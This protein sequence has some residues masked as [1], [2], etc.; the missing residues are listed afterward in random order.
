[1][2]LMKEESDK[3]EFVCPFPCSCAWR[4]AG[5]PKCSAVNARVRCSEYISREEMEKAKE[6]GESWKLRPGGSNE[7]CPEK[8]K[9]K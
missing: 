6:K 9:E 5:K 7:V 1:M 3:R 8:K 2:D 4:Q